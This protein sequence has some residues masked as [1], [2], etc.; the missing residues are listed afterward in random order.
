MMNGGML[1]SA[2]NSQSKIPAIDTDI[3]EIQTHFRSVILTICF[4]FFLLKTFQPILLDWNRENGAYPFR[5]ST[6][7]WVSRIILTVFFLAWCVTGG[8]RWSWREWKES[9]PFVL[10]AICTVANVL[11]IYLTVQYLGSGSYAVLKNFNLPFTA[12][13]MVV[14]L[15]RNVSRTQWGSVLMITIALLIFRANVLQESEPS[16]GYGFV[17]LGVVASTYE[18]VLLQLASHN[19]SGMSFQKQSFFYHFYSMIL[20]SVLMVTLDYDVVFMGPLG[21]FT[22]W[23]F[24]VALYLLCVVPLIVTKHAV[25]GLAST[26]VVKL[27]NSATTVSTFVLAVVLFAESGTL[28]EI[29]ACVTICVGLVVYQLDE[30]DSCDVEKGLELLEGA[31]VPVT[32]DRK[33]IRCAN[34][35]RGVAAFGGKA[36]AELDDQA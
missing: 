8:E 31:F 15:G 17:L 6:S 18:G 7:I 16:P 19:L 35:G 21:P 36:D 30:L 26:I 24:K 9:L 12:V 2:H 34:C 22:G 10:V 25:A 11:S 23:N 14:W 3:V 4:S 29:L 1:A 33:I 13:V 5:P 28:V 27:I 32:H 20:S